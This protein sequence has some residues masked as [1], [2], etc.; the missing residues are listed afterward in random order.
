MMLGENIDQETYEMMREQ[1]GLND[2][3]LQRYLRYVDD[4]FLHFDMGTSYTTKQ[5]VITEILTCTPNTLKLTACSMAAAIVLGL[6]L[7]VIAAIRQNGIADSIISMVSLIGISFPS[8]FFKS[9]GMGEDGT[10]GLE[11]RLL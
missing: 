5:P 1:M 6:F 2:S 7:G 11:D 8:F 9:V 3:F 4:L 10:A